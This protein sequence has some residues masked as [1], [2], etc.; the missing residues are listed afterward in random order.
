[1]SQKTV[2][3]D[4][5]S[6]ER[7]TALAT[8]TDATVKLAEKYAGKFAAADQER[9][10][11]HYDLGTDLVKVT[12]DET[13]Y[14]TDA[15]PQ[16]AKYLGVEHGTNGMLALKRWAGVFDR[17][18]VAEYT[19]KTFPDGSRLSVQHW[20]IV[21]RVK[22]AAD[23][24][25]LLKR[26]VAEGLSSRQVSSL[27]AGIA[28]V[29]P[30]GAGGR[31]PRSPLSAAAAL[32]KLHALCYALHNYMESSAAE[33]GLG[34]IEELD[35]NDPTLGEKVGHMVA[36]VANAALL[37]RAAADTIQKRVG[38]VEDRFAAVRSKP[39]PKGAKPAVKVAKP[40]TP[41]KAAAKTAA[42]V[43]PKVATKTAPKAAKVQQ[44]KLR[45]LPHPSVNGRVDPG[46]N[47]ASPTRRRPRNTTYSNSRIVEA[48]V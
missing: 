18:T 36:Q 20:V 31:A 6:T 13:R 33:T 19:G 29:N 30:G 32:K 4:R 26:A 37:A 23:R 21:T 25:K 12:S 8:M 5:K 45:D 2:D 47:G 16:L 15:L 35:P 17:K 48:A 40:K 41:P 24:V 14:G 28:M 43:A 3:S 1:M 27:V 10:L 38:T 7:N 22:A 34:M 44:E 42:K 39:L 46:L 9:V 11:A